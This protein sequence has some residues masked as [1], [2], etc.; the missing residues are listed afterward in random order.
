MISAWL[1]M[2]TAVVAA[3]YHNTPLTVATFIISTLFVMS[4]SGVF[5]GPSDDEDEDEEEEDEPGAV[6]RQEVRMPVRGQPKAAGLPGTRS[7]LTSD[8][9]GCDPDQSEI[10]EERRW[11]P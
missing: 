7:D 5:D 9:V 10:Y 11:D 4:A 6:E 8:R 2:I 1:V 3:W